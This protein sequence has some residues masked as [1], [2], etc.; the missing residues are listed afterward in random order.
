MTGLEEK[1]GQLTDAEEAARDALSDSIGRV[2]DINISELNL[3][4]HRAIS[5]YLSALEAQ[6]LKI[7]PVEPSMEM[8]QSGFEALCEDKW[9]ATQAVWVGAAYAAMLNAV[10]EG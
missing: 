10:Q 8:L 2:T 9:D 6:G 3:A 5:A 7:V 4:T 1:W